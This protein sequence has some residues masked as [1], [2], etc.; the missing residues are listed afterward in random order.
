MAK[1]KKSKKAGPQGAGT[2]SRKRKEKRETQK[3]PLQRVLVIRNNKRIL[4]WRPWG[5]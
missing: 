1:K 3:T 4:E 2:T 5:S